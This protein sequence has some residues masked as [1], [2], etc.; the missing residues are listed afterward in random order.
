M[1]KRLW[2]QRNQKGP[3][4][5]EPTVPNE[6]KSKTTRNRLDLGVFKP[7]HAPKR[8]YHHYA[9]LMTRITRG[10]KRPRVGHYSPP[11]D[12]AWSKP[13]AEEKICW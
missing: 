9:P 3:N 10:A 5:G 8:R 2:H 1:V 4:S 11:N 6:V 12:Y 7:K 13:L